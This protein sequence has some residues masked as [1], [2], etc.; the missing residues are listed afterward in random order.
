M[1]YTSL[2]I[3]DEILKIAKRNNRSLTPMQLNK[4]TY[5][6]HG[7]ALANDYPDL[8]SD[9][10]EAWKY[11]PVIPRLYRATKV[12]GRDPIPL[13]LID[14]QAL[15][16]VNEETRALLEDVFRKYGHFS[17]YTLSSL[18][19]QPGTPWEQV[20]VDGVQNIEIP[21]H[22]IKQHYEKLI[23]DRKSRSAA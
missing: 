12:Y 6:A 8:F 18:T 20:Y 22:I 17:A 13:E 21:D 4:L 5:I 10:I 7:I 9:R 19:H 2:T 3:A 11:G 23:N 16:N 1:T 15:P 14:E